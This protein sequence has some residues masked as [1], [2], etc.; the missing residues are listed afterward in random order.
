MPGL[1]VDAIARTGPILTRLGE[2]DERLRAGPRHA[3]LGTGSIHASLI[4]GGQEYSS[5]PAF[6]D[7]DC[8]R[9]TVP[10]ETDEDVE[11]EVAE[12]VAGIDASWQLTVTRDPFEVDQDEEIVGL[13]ARHAAEPERV[14]MPFWTD[15][16]L[17]GVAGIPTVLF[18]PCGEGA[19]AEVEWVSI[20]SLE[21]CVGTYLAVAAELCA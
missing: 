5:Y 2:L 21:R 4:S 8:E 10:G 11:H 14:G 19:H 12:L 16:A 1:G 18:G 7:L 3:L 9:R 6:C 13:V 20:S 15:A 17:L